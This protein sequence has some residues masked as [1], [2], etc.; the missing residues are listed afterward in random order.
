MKKCI[1]RSEDEEGYK[2]VYKWGCNDHHRIVKM[3]KKELG[4]K[5][6]EAD[7]EIDAFIKEEEK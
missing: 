1:Y 2:E 7:T 5:I 4:I 6:N 3:V